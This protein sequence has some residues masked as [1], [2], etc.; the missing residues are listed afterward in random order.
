MKTISARSCVVIAGILA[1][2]TA[3]MAASPRFTAP[4]DPPLP[5][6]RPAGID[7]A[8]T[9]PK[10]R[11]VEPARELSEELPDGKSGAPPP[12]TP[13]E[14]EI[15]TPTISASCSAFLTSARVEAK[16]APPP[17]PQHPGCGIDEPVTISAIVRPDGRKIGVASS[18]VMRCAM[19]KEFAAWA[20]GEFSTIL[21]TGDR[22]IETIVTGA[23]YQCRPRN[24]VPGAKM[25]EHG[26]GNALDI[27][28][29]KFSGGGQAMVGDKDAP[30]PETLFESACR[31]FATVLGPGSDGYHKDHMH[32]DL[33]QRRGGAHY[34]R[35]RMP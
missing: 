3:A 2:Q 11:P 34:C 15:V 24:R 23:S 32:I 12:A 18:G 1:L 25:S 7:P 16:R 10:A 5:P 13:A 14:A 33:R 9:P 8:K 6:P 26:L 27:R 21:E 35:W 4:A 22:K 20:A 31:N 29:V 17:P 30:I 19:A 28:G